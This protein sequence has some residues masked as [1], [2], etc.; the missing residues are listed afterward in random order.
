MFFSFF[1]FTLDI[2]TT[3]SEFEVKIEV[4]SSQVHVEFFLSMLGRLQCSSLNFKVVLT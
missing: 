1:F 3:K 4:Y 2:S